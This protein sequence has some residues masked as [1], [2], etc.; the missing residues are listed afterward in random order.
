VGGVRS[1][2]G[3]ASHGPSS[4]KG[5]GASQGCIL[6]EEDSAEYSVAVLAMVQEALEHLQRPPSVQ[7]Q[8]PEV[9]PGS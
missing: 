4:D 5:G 1:L 2:Q 6:Q 8:Q 7:V 3:A 9:K